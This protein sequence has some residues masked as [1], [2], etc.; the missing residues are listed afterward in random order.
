M[1]YLAVLLA[2]V[3]VSVATCAQSLILVNNQVSGLSPFRS[4]SLNKP[5]DLDERPP[6]LRQRNIGR[7]MAIG[8]AVLGFAGILIYSDARSGRVIAQGSVTQT[9]EENK[10]LAGILMIEGG[11]GLLIPGVIIWKKGQ[12]KYSRYLERQTVSLSAAGPGLT[13]RYSL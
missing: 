3:L 2:M 8:G 10:M 7:T 13:L 1:K 12:K 11:I 5:L 6:G 9:P 4:I